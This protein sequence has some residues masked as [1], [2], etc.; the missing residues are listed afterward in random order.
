MSSSHPQLRIQWRIARG[1]GRLMPVL[2]LID[3]K[4]GGIAAEV[5]E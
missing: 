3:S 4:I 2:M 5:K 1:S